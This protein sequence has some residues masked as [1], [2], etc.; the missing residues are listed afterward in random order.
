MA[1]TTSSLPIG[2][3]SPIGEVAQRM[4]AM[5]VRQDRLGDPIDAFEVEEVPTP[6]PGAGL[7]GGAVAYAREDHI[8]VDYVTQHL[9]EKAGV[10][11]FA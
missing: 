8:T 7:L 10:D 1:L 6:Q 11:A 9:T 4:L 3:L 5:V 2:T